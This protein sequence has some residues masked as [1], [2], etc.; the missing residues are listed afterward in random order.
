M[1]TFPRKKKGK[2]GGQ[3]GHTGRTLQQIE[4]PDKTAKHK[5]GPCVS[6]AETR[7]VFDLPQ[8]KLEITAHLLLKGQSSCSV[9]PGSESSYHIAECGL[10]DPIQ[11]DSNI[12]Q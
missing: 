10:Y 11:E 3:Q 12:V 7:R 1:L 5:P 6:V 9:W 4:H 2:Q 8:P